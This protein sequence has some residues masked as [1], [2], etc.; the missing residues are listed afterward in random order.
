MGEAGQGKRKTTVYWSEDTYE[1]LRWLAYEQRTSI[2][3]LVVQAVEAMLPEAQKPPRRS[4]R[5]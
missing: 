5:R 3:K 4:K 1:A 2:N